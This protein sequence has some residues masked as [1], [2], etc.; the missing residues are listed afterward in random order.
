MN[1]AMA[2]VVVA[3]ILGAAHGFARSA[4]YEVQ[5]F[6]IS[7]VQAQLLVPRSMKEQTPTPVLMLSGMPASP[8]QMMA[9][10]PPR[11]LSPAQIAERLAARDYSDVR[12][13]TPAADEISAVRN[14]I[15]VV[16]IVDT[17]TGEPK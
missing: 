7:Q 8:T 16:L 4:S 6:P 1:R 14:G 13:L 17:R 5:D 10:T 12:V 2:V 3:A 15:P 11:P 9:L